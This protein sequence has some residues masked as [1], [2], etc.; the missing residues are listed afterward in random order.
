[1]KDVQGSNLSIVDV[2]R[3]MQRMVK[4]A[5]DYQPDYVVGINRGGAIVG[6]W[7]AKQLG[8][9]GPV[10][11]IVNSDEPPEKRVIP[12]SSRDSALSG[13][14]YLVDDAQRKG[15][16]MREATNYLRTKHP[17]AQIR[18]AVLLQMSVPHT[19][20]EAIAFR[21]TRS[22]FNGFTTRDANVTLPWDEGSSV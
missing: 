8:C 11:V 2:Q 1:M 18:R 3:A 22:E 5:R 17:N 6:G 7:L 15:E 16:H 10:I 20:P 19:G 13:K 21:G 14:I 9:G 12:Q 4:D